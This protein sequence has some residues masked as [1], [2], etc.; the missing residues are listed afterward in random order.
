MQYSFD[1]ITYDSTVV[2]MFKFFPEISM[3]GIIIQKKVLD[4]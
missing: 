2:V 3:F 1:S 4:N